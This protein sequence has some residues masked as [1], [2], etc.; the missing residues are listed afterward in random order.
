MSMLDTIGGLSG[1]LGGSGGVGSSIPSN[2]SAATSAATSTIN[3]NV[4]LSGSAI[5][6]GYQTLGPFS[7]N[8]PGVETQ[9]SDSINAPTGISVKNPIIIGAIAVA[10]VLMFILFRK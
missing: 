9:G 1:G 5:G 2:Q 4:N 8:F 7:V 6:G 10:I 3:P